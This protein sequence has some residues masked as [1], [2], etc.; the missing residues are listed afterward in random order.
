MSTKKAFQSLQRCERELKQILQEAA[1]QGEYDR[2]FE[3]GR[4]A[5]NVAALAAEAAVAVND[6]KSGDEGESDA[7]PTPSRQSQPSR[8]PQASKRGAGRPARRTTGKAGQYP[9]FAR[10][11]DLLVKVGWS[12]KQKREYH[13][14]APKKVAELLRDAFMGSEAD[15]KPVATDV[16]FPLMD[17]EGVEQPDYQAYVCLAW[18]K[19]EGL[20]VQDGRLGYRIPDRKG[21]A[22]AF[23]ARWQALPEV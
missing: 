15:T 22:E 23:V 7:N 5:R 20:V 17:E 4:W 16:L 1:G 2:L 6:G 10:H 19:T 3:V 8:P 14:K 21:F 12:K 13:H 11:L 18:L 9:R